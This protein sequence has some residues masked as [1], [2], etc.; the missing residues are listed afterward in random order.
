MR[1]LKFAVSKCRPAHVVYDLKD[2]LLAFRNLWRCCELRSSETV[3]EENQ[4]VA[5]WARATLVKI[6]L[7]VRGFYTSRPQMQRA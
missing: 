2:D 3:F 4:P 6:R 5:L 7:T 1:F